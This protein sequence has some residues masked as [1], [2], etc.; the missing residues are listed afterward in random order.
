MIFAIGPFAWTSLLGAVAAGIA[1]LLTGS[2]AQALLLNRATPVHAM[3][4]MALWAVAWAGTKPIASLLD[5]VLASQLGI[6]WAAG[7]MAF[8]AICIAITEISL[9]PQLKRS[10]KAWIY[11]RTGAQQHGAPQ[12]AT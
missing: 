7:I 5:G 6:H 12:S 11:N 4:V 3:H 8:P 9:G 2:A 1:G 10:L